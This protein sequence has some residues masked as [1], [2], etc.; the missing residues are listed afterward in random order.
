M[1]MHTVCD[2]VKQDVEL[3]VVVNICNSLSADACLQIVR[4]S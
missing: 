1:V 2:N 4:R 3:Q